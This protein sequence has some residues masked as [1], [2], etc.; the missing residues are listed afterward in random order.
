MVAPC[1][2]CTD[3]EL[4]CHSKCEKYK[5]FKEW[6]DQA[7]EKRR[8]EDSLPTITKW[9]FEGYTLHSGKRRRHRR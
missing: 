6:N 3:R 8:Q 1:K 7:R 9:S 2:D 4:G 5:A